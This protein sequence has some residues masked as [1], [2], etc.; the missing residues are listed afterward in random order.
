[1]KRNP[2]YQDAVVAGLAELRKH[3]PFSPE[4][5]EIFMTLIRKAYPPIE[6]GKTDE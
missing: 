6:E 4:Q 2:D 5:F 3:H 1:M